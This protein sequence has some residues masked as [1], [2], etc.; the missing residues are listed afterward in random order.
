MLISI[1]YEHL[2][3]IWLYILGIQFR[4]WTSL[5][6]VEHCY[7]VPLIRL[8][9]TLSWS[10]H[11]NM[12]TLVQLRC[13]ELLSLLAF[14]RLLIWYY[15]SQTVSFRTWESDAHC[16]SPIVPWHGAK[17]FGISSHWTIW[18]CLNMSFFKKSGSWFKNI[19]LLSSYW[20]ISTK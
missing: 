16:L 13:K 9:Y 1:K 12:V 5:I 3:F 6:H 11:Q 15:L 10:R 17:S 20:F 7:M 19:I 14:T 4:F 18:N 8:C 2:Y